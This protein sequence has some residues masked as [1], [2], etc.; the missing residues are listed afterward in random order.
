MKN[1]YFIDEGREERFILDNYSHIIWA[2]RYL[3]AGDFEIKTSPSAELLEVLSTWAFFV[4]REGSDRTM[5][6]EYMNIHTDSEKGD[7]L[8]IRG[9]S[10]ESI[11]ERRVI[12]ENK[13]ISGNLHEQL[14]WL[15]EDNIGINAGVT[16]RVNIIEQVYSTDPVVLYYDVE[17][18]YIGKTLYDIVVD[19]CKTY[20]LGWKLTLNNSTGIL[21]LNFYF[22]VDRSLLQTDNA[23][24]EFSN[25]LDNLLNSD[26]VESRENLKNVCYVAGE[27]GIGNLKEIVLIELTP[28]IS[29]MNRREMYY[30]SNIRRNTSSGQLTDQEY[31]NQ[32]TYR[33][34]EELAKRQEVQAFDGEVDTTQY[35]YGDEFD[36]GDILQI[37]DKF[38]NT[39]RSRVMELIYS[40]DEAGEKIYP[41]F[42]L[43]DWVSPI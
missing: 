29:G 35:N 19:I 15:I 42:S 34:L 9:R 23:Y 41:T 12:Y 13:V 2:D 1:V 4:Q 40:F 6:F 26:Y 33:G 39:T 38:G 30:D 25:E 7:Y 21:Y 16:R 43:T 36:M 28:G 17:T 22:G 11:F 18:Q 32:L 14:Q 27:E 31:I 24:V 5:L 20:E 8:I 37:S 10:L 3:E